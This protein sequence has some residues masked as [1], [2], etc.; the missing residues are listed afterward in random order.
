MKDTDQI[1]RTAIV[2]VIGER[3]PLNPLDMFP[4]VNECE[5]IQELMLCLKEMTVAGILVKGT[6]GQYRFSQKTLKDGYAEQLGTDLDFDL[7]ETLMPV[8]PEEVIT[9]SE[10]VRDLAEL[11]RAL[12]ETSEEIKKQQDAES[13]DAIPKDGDLVEADTDSLRRETRHRKAI[14]R[15]NIRILDRRDQFRC[16]RISDGTLALGRRYQVFECSPEDI[17]IL[18]DY[19][20]QPLPA[21]LRKLNRMYRSAPK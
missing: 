7:S 20:D 19:L 17:L 8:A 9:G 6:L 3:G 5:R 15:S 11:N 1:I 16:A 13:I 4:L 12:S 14:D 2:R 18:Q 21:W 10:A